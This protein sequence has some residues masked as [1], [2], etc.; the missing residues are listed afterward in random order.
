MSPFSAKQI[1]PSRQ[2]PI[3]SGFGATTT[4]VEALAG[5][6][7]SGLTAIVTGGYSGLGTETTRVLSEAGATV[8]VPARDAAKAG[9]ALA[10][11]TRVELESLDLADPASIDAF[12]GRFLA[13]GRALPVL[14]NS[15]GVMAAPLTRDARGHELQF[16]TNH[17]GHFRLAAR[18]WPALRAAQ[19]ARVVSV[20]SAGHH[21]GPVDF[22]D[23]N[24]ERRD[25]DKWQAYGQSKTANALF[26]LE[27]DRRG[28]SHGVRA[29]SV[30]PGA[31][32]TDLVRHL[33]IEDF[34]RFGLV[35]EATGEVRLE[36]RQGFKTVEQG[37]ATQIWCAT[38]PQLNGLGGVYCED[39]DVAEPVS[40]TSEERRGVSPWAMDPEAAARLWPLSERLADIRFDVG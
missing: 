26:A 22:D 4:A 6:D 15:A 3:R 25:Y 12:A 5:R 10:G 32:L 14:I 20:S 40:G 28:E 16:T 29:F 7:L 19:G 38:S 24:F 11:M 33:D 31:I 23:P 35:D 39:C 17:L 37:A 13:S 34:R 36:R 21:F 30:H 8:V 2:F 18:L 1:M 27:L 9:A